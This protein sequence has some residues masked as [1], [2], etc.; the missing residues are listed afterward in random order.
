MKSAG[1][2][3]SRW[4]TYCG[5]EDGN[6]GLKG[7]QVKE[8]VELLP[9]SEQIKGVDLSEYKDFIERVGQVYCLCRIATHGVMV[10][11]EKCRE[12]YHSV[13]LGLSQSQV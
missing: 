11:C 8:L 12:W 13:C 7:T 10:E 4:E 6:G 1:E 9:E 3:I 5:E 2:W